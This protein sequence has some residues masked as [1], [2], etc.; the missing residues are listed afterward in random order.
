[1]NTD[2]QNVG[3]VHT[4]WRYPVKSMQG[5]MVD[6]AIITAHG[7][8]GD[9]SYA[10]VEVETGHV[11]SAKHP[12]KW[13]Q[14]L[15]CR[16]AYL[17]PPG[18]AGTLPPIQITLPDGSTVTSHD[19]DVDRV[20]SA[21]LGREVRLVGQSPDDPVDR[22]IREAN[23]APVYEIESAEDIRLEPMGR[24]TPGGTF[25]DYAPLLLLTT[26]SLQWLRTI[27][28]G[29]DFDV[30]RFRPNMVI[31]PRDEAAGLVENDWLGH[32][33]Q[34]GER[35]TLHVFDPCPRCVIT[36]LAQRELAHDVQILRTVA[37]HTAAQSVTE[38]PGQDM[39]AV[40]GVYAQAETGGT[41][42][43]GDAVQVRR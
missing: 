39:P 1:M 10:L 27:T 9:R 31:E 25:V 29:S 30:R 19:P 41:V 5:E 24:A 3:T 34:I 22:P 35:L 17:A 42:R 14:V 12:R 38:A 26:A 11:V 15:Q 2:L 4:I 36:T 40:V 6:E 21:A 33:L 32:H 8:R 23:R 18:A 7:L 13:A 37:Q 16:A 28:P 43:S 20:L